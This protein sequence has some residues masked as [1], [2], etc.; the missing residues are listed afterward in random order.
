MGRV[1]KAVCQRATRLLQDERARVAP[2][3][4]SGLEGAVRS[5]NAEVEAVCASLLEDTQAASASAAAVRQRAVAG[6]EQRSTQ[7]QLLA[8]A[9]TVAAAQPADG[10]LTGP[11]MVAP[12]ALELLSDDSDNDGSDD[13]VEEAFQAMEDGTV[14][15]LCGNE[16]ISDLFFYLVRRPVVQGGH[17]VVWKPLTGSGDT[18]RSRGGHVYLADVLAVLVDDKFCAL[19]LESVYPNL[20][21]L[22]VQAYHFQDFQHWRVGLQALLHEQQASEPQVVYSDAIRSA[23][24]HSWVVPLTGEDGIGN[25][26]DGVKQTQVDTPDNGLGA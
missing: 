10:V 16:H 13:A 8:R 11:T 17:M 4:T 21:A 23:H 7:N 14:L 24:V 9:A 20:P 22:S 25:G 15:G 12:P 6:A 1:D 26:A 3:W 19:Q 2:A 5:V 18:A